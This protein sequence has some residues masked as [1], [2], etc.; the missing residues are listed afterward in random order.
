M[1]MLFYAVTFLIVFLFGI[2]IGSFLN[3]LIYRIPLKLDFVKGRSFC[4]NCKHQLKAIDLVPI[5][6]F[7][8]LQ[9]KC[10]YCKAKISP[11]YP[12]IEGLCGV[13]FV[14]NFYVIGFDTPLM[15]LRSVIAC[16]L[17]A[18]LIV[19]A[20]IDFDCMIIPNGMIV[21]LFIIAALSFCYTGLNGIASRIIGMFIV[22]LPLLLF[23]AFIP[24]SFGGGDVKL[25]AACGLLLGWKNTLLATFIGI[26]LGGIAALIAVA[27]NKG[28]NET[29]TEEKTL[30]S[31]ALAKTES[32][33]KAK[34]DKNNKINENEQNDENEA[35]KQGGLHIPFGPWLAIGVYIAYLF[36]E[37]I[38]KWYL[39]LLC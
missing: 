33:Q 30:E 8:F 26:I 25:M 23:A 2:T 31:P 38:I 19:V 10:R 27:K 37:N 36:G 6:S 14:L 9:G 35:E 7:M 3:V 4:P 5:F 17:T 32:K 12:L 24:G 18:A 39:G 11:R 22:S 34:N 16:A 15:I 28:K 1:Q 13:L 20:M 29:E 21:T